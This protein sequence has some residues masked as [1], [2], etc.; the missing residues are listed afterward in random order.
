[1]DIK[2]QR[3]A[4]DI[5]YDHSHEN[6]DLEQRENQIPHGGGSHDDMRDSYEFDMDCDE[7]GKDEVPIELKDRS[8]KSK[9]ARNFM[10]N[11]QVRKEE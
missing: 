11:H 4:K 9:K 2:N 8:L 10:M 6:I 7:L 1:M 5:L 3:L